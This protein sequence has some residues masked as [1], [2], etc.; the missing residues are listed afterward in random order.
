MFYKNPIVRFAPLAIRGA[1]FSGGMEF[2][3]PVAHA[4]TT[5]DKVNWNLRKHER[6]ISQRVDWRAGAPLRFALDDHFDLF[7]DRC[8][9]AQDVYLFNP[10]TLPGRY[11]YW[12][13]ASLDANEGTEFI[14][15]LHRARSY[16]FAGSASWPFARLDLIQE[17]PGLP[18]MEGVPCG[19]HGNFRASEF[20]LAEEHARPGIHFWQRCSVGLFWCLAA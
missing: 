2:S 7:P 12:T 11:H 9:L 5:A 6:W 1:F 4:P 18:G 15:P 14:Y 10:G 20:S 19:P 16:E 13:N 3:F 8:A 17:E